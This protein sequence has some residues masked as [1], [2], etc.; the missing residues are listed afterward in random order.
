MKIAEIGIGSACHTSSS[1]NRF[2][3][4]IQGDAST[5]KRLKRL[6][7]LANLPGS[8]VPNDQRVTTLKKDVT[9][10][11]AKRMTCEETER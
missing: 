5:L 8:T 2:M 1:P 6:K 4:D 7:N 10:E 11:K 9:K 3:L